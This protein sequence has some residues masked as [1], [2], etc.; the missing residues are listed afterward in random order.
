MPTTN[1]IGEVIEDNVKDVVDDVIKP[2]GGG[3]GPGPFIDF[4]AADFL[5]ADFL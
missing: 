3:P 5:K 4:L 1:T 2:G